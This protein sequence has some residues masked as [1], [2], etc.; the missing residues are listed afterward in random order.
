MY[1]CCMFF[2]SFALLFKTQWVCDLWVTFYQDN[3]HWKVPSLL[4]LWLCRPSGG[5]T[6]SG[7]CR[8]V[9]PNCVT[10]T[11]S[12]LVLSLH[13]GDA[14]ASALNLCWT[15]RTIYLQYFYT[16]WK[17]QKLEKCMHLSAHFPD[18]KEQRSGFKIF[19]LYFAVQ[20]NDEAFFPTHRIFINCIP[21]RAL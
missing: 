21:Y 3:E 7:L 5:W 12:Q 20:L 10:K 11:T 9:W 18:D 14:K 16:K 2:S 8:I 19:L 13:G 1:L 17:H 6:P 15:I 4:Q